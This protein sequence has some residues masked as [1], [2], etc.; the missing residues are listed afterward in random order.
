MCH[1]YFAMFDFQGIEIE[2]VI[3]L[4]VENGSGKEQ[5][6]GR[7]RNTATTRLSPGRSRAA[8]VMVCEAETLKSF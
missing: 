6:K 7:S 1:G 3:L 5:R 2:D 4:A 8:V